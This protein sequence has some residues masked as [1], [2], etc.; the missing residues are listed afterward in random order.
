MKSAFG[1]HVI[2]IWH[3]PTD[4]DWADKLKAEADAGADFGTLA[5]DNSEGDEADDGGNLGWV[6]KGQL[7]E[8]V[9]L[10]VFQTPVG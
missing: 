9:D 7:P 4:R 5:R 8:L 3:R 2:Q 6:A 10:K 1:W